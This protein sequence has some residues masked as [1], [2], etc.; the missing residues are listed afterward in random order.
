MVGH[1]LSR[2]DRYLGATVTIE[3]ARWQRGS[4]RMDTDVVVVGSGAG[5]AMAASEIAQGGAR[6]IVLEEGPALRLED[7]LQREVEMMARLYQERGGRATNDLAIR[8]LGGRNVGGSTV[9]N[10]NLCKRIPDPILESWARIHRVSG[11]G[12]G[13][14]APVFAAVERQLRVS[15]VDPREYNRNNQLLVRGVEQLG[16][17]GGGLAHNRVGCQGSGFCE[18]GC[19]FDAKQ[20]ASKVLLPLAERHGALV[21]SDA[22]VIRVRHRAGRAYG[23]EAVALDADGRARGEITVDAGAVVLAGSAIGSAVVAALSRLPD[24]YGQLGRGLR[25]HPGV[26]VAGLFDER[27]DGFRGIPQAYECTEWLDLAESSDRRVWITTVFAHPVS[28]AVMLPGFGA[29]HRQW[30][31]RYSRLAV[32]TAMV[33]D[34]SSGHVGVRED[35]RARIHYVLEPDDSQQ[36][37]LG[38]RACARL[39][40]A[41]GARQVLVPSSPPHVL[42]RADQV[43]AVPDSVGRPHQIAITSVHPLGTMRLGDDP[44]RAVVSSRAEHHQV[45]GLFVL[46]GSLFPTSIGVPPQLSIYAFAR[47]LAR[48]VIERV[49]ER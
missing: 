47:H 37:G 1:R 7:M 2:T 34:H 24:P 46:D 14:L 3:Q 22:R 6:V 17:R 15:S 40:F 32:L 38:I 12:P 35:G 10:L 18:L 9:H 33:H 11:C 45:R 26:A 48:H 25:L 16:W 29:W 36:L 23:V 13:D 19:P 4:R 30:M 39:L 41:A 8:V 21:L 20:N 5:G 49:S 31:L 42:D 28:A 27:V 43:E 44:R